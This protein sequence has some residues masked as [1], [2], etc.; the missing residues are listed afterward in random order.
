MFESPL[1]KKVFF[2]D[3][4]A[5]EYKNRKNLLNIACHSEDFGECL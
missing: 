5:A 1:K 2:S 3:R 4:S